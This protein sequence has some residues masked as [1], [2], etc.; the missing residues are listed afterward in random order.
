ME[1]SWSRFKQLF[2]EL[3][4]KYIPAKKV[5]NCGRMKKP[6]WMSHKAVKLV[7]KKNRVFSKYRDIG[8]PYSQV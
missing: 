2:L 5:Q 7:R 3:E 6:M 4:N 1:D 8:S